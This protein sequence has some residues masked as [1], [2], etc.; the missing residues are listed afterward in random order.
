MVAFTVFFYNVLYAFTRG[1]L[2]NEVF[3]TTTT[4]ESFTSTVTTLLEPDSCGSMAS[5]LAGIAANRPMFT[6][7]VHTPCAHPMCTSHVHTPC[8]R[9]MS[10]PA[11]AL[12]GSH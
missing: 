2:T 11:L 1:V 7:C 5:N 8:A 10:T 6:P 3:A 4:S 12:T 9:P